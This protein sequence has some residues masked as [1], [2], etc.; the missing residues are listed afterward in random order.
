M[1]RTPGLAVEVDLTIESGE[2]QLSVHGTGDRV[3]VSIPSLAAANDVFRTGI[4]RARLAGLSQLLRQTGLM[5]TV[6]T[7]RRNLIT[8][9]HPKGSWLLR[10]IGLPHSRIHVR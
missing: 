5:V 4:P 3:F 9:G 6:Q 8:I 10:L 2:H 7:P 1:S